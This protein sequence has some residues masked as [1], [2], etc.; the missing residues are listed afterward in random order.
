MAKLLWPEVPMA[1][2]SYGQVTM[3][4]LWPELLWHLVKQPLTKAA[5]LDQLASEQLLPC[6]HAL[7]KAGV[8]SD[9]P[10]SQLLPLELA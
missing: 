4:I 8:L 10:T 9:D 2:S 5:H 1:R 7:A 3:V 6:L